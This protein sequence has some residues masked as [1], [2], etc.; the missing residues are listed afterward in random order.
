MSE[1]HIARMDRADLMRA[2]QE[3]GRRAL[4]SPGFSDERKQAIALQLD[5]LES[6]AVQPQD[7][8][9]AAIIKPVLNGLQLSLCT[10][11]D[12]LQTWNTWGPALVGFF[13]RTH[14]ASSP[15]RDP[16]VPAEAR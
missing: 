6:E 14:G 2:I 3:I 8:R 11:S 5:F 15:V 1:S 13:S 16:G 7:A 10:S 12:M 4:R 9:K